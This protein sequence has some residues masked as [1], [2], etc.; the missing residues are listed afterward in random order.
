M[1]ES[2]GRRQEA[3]D[4]RQEARGKRRPATCDLQPATCNL[5]PVTCNL[6]PATCLL[7]LASCV[8]LFICSSKLAVATSAASTW[9][10]YT[11]AHGLADNAVF[12]LAIGRDGNLWAGTAGGV[13]RFDSRR[14]VTYPL[15]DLMGLEDPAG[16]M[17]T[18]LA[19]DAQGRIWCGTYGS[20][21]GVW[22]RDRWITYNHENSGLANDWITA[23]ALDE[24][25]RLWIGT[26]GGGV[27]VFDGHRWITYN[28]VNSCLPLD[29]V[30][31]LTIGKQ[32]TVWVGT[33]GK[34]LCALDTEGH[35]CYT[36]ANSGLDNDYV[37]ALIV[38]PDGR[39][40]IGSESGINAFDPEAGLWWRWR[41][42]WN[43]PQQRVRALAL[44]RQGRLWVGTGRGLAIYDG[45][46]WKT[47]PLDDNLV[48]P[49]V[50]AIIS[51]AADNIWVGTLG[52][53]LSYYGQ[54][55]AKP[56]FPTRPVILVHGWRGPDSDRVEDSEF[57]FLKRWLE[58]DGH[59]V[60]Y[61]TGIHPRNTLHENAQQL[62]DVIAQAKAA[63]GAPSVDI[64]A[65]SMGG[66]NT[67]AYLESALY[68]RD[69]H[70][71]FIMGTP[72]AGVYLWKTFLL[73]EIAHW[74]D[75][76]SARELLPEYVALF[77]ETHRNVWQVPYF[78]VAGAARGKALPPLFGF[79]PPSDGLIS[80]W[81][82]HALRGPTVR[83]ITTG[84]L[85]A[86]ADETMLLDIPSFLWPRDTYDAHLRRALREEGFLPGTATPPA[87]QPLPEEAHSPLLEGEISPGQAVT[88]SLEIEARGAIRLYARWQRGNLTFTLTNPACK[89]I[90][91]EVAAK[92]E[93]IAYFAL[94]FANFASFVITDALPGTWF[95]HLEAPK[96]L[97]NPVG[98][99]VYA[100]LGSH[101]KLRAAT[102]REW[103]HL[104]E[105]VAIRATLQEDGKP[106][107]GAKVSAEVYT[108]PRQRTSLI[109]YDDGQ[110]GDD[111][112]NDGVYSNVWQA[113][114]AG[115][116]YPFFVSATGLWGGQRFAR[117]YEGVIPVSPDTASLTDYHLEEAEDSN[118]DGK[119]ERL[120]IIIGVK[121]VKESR[122]L[123][124]ARLLDGNQREIAATVLP[125]TLRPGL[126][127]VTL[128]FA[129]ELIHRYGADGPYFVGHLVLMDAS[130]AA[131][132][133]DQRPGFLT[134]HYR[135][136]DFASP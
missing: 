32:G 53:G 46:A 68:N 112:A 109:L 3:R 105:P 98:Y 49:A 43:L 60:F 52:G 66:L 111:S 88:R 4:K 99:A 37:T 125:V 18:A 41:D 57:V 72:H 23:L 115:G 129:G 89:R 22:E 55:G 116:Y 64:I 80:A 101:L 14:W 20:G 124:A 78:L 35:C 13:S 94:P 2:R 15:Q 96:A 104:G 136:R 29:W 67:R 126:H 90:S 1:Q 40:W 5:Q 27:I 75:E 106:V 44:D 82:A 119:Y 81:S 19:A 118:R 16:L 31:S 123:L 84:D 83:Y 132:R 62:R 51:D 34:G 8:L 28:A 76:P 120:K 108:A 10:T 65:F 73:H 7:L 102:Y 11:T 74:S 30:T 56:T 131:I 103:Y 86:W 39:I 107:P 92:E 134:A 61:A 33:H 26:W 48:Q 6:Q 58:Q 45:T 25:Q 122:F 77:N 97:D 113:A 17:V 71:V 121:V 50:G 87:W 38:A 130:G 54:D 36:T 79:L 24:R 100:V 133:L 114:G 12:A 69:V 70:Q 63:T 117:G 91:A 135:W 93:N 21:L 42:A 128:P 85:H 95:C 110:H 9:L 47:V 59:I 127:A